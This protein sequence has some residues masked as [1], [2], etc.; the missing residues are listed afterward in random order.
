MFL[1]AFVLE[2]QAQKYDQAKE[3]YEEFILL[4]PGHVMADDARYSI[5]NM[6]K[7]P[8]ELIEEFERQDSIRQAQEA[9]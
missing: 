1:K 7:T 5:E 4:Y 3:V 8:E 9:A 2:N 6:G